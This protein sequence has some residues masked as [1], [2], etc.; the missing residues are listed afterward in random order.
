MGVGREL[1]RESRRI[2]GHGYLSVKNQNLVME[3]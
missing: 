3:R 1:F 2:I